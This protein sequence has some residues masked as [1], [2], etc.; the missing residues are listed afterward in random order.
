MKIKLAIL[1]N[2]LSYLSK[3]ANVFGT[4]YAEKFEVYSF[5]DKQVA[6]EEIRNSRIDIFLADESFTID[7]S[8]LPKDCGFAYFVDSSDVDRIKGQQ[9]I[10]KYQRTDLIYREILGLYSEKRGA[11]VE[12]RMG[13]GSTAVVAFVSASGGAGSST[14]AA[15][16]AMRLTAQG[17]RVLYLDLEKCGS[18]ETIFVG[19]GQFDMSD[20]I[21]AL[22]SKKA[23]IALKLESCVKRD[24]NGVFFYSQPKIALDMLEFGSEEIIRFVE[25]LKSTGTYDCI[26]MDVDFAITSDMMRIYRAAQAVVWVGDGTEVSNGKVRRICT[27]IEAMQKSSK[28]SMLDSMRLLY[29]KFSSTSGVVIEFPGLK[30]LG[31]APRYANATARQIAEQLAQLDVFDKVL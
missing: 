23:N 12:L 1:G 6:L 27:A 5:T 21:F 20:I 13:G 11:T 30:V 4:K 25:E 9:A 16:Y 8:A 28:E 29:N 10:C 15:A 17:R 3:I 22:K 2:D 31:G 7:T 18:S 19:E 26:V 14:M 24:P